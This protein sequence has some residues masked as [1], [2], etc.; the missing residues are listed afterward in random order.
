MVLTVV[1]ILKLA[2]FLESNGVKK[3][4][5]VGVFMTNSPEMVIIILA[6]SKLGA[7]GALINT[8]L[9]GIPA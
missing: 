4:D 7:I 3:G 6:L 5:Y 9:R 8:S 1:E 2:A